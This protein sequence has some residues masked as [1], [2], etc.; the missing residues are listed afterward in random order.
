IWLAK[1]GARRSG[2][3]GSEPD[4]LRTWRCK[5][6]VKASREK[7]ACGTLSGIARVGGT[8]ALLVYRRD[9]RRES[10]RTA[11]EK[12]SLRQFG[13][14]VLDRFGP[15]LVPLTAQVQEVG[16]DLPLQ[17]ALRV[18]ELSTD[19]LVEDLLVVRVLR[20]DVVDRLD[21]RVEF[22]LRSNG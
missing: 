15:D 16:H 10:A 1:A 9:P 22:L 5:R 11:T 20:D 7:T 21:L 13:D 18:E 19:V 17:A 6:E 4:R 14:V 3:T 2:M 12:E 8:R